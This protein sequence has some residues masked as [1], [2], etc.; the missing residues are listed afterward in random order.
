[1]VTPNATPDS[2]DSTEPFDFNSATYF[3]P[4]CTLIS[5]AI[6]SLFVGQISDKVGRKSVL[7][8]MG[9]LS[10]IGSIVKYF[11]RNTF[12]SFCISN[13][14]FGLFLGNLP[15]AMAYIGEMFHSKKE[16]ED[17][18]GVI[19]G[20]FVM[21]NSGGGI[22]AILMAESG[23]FAPLW[24]GA[25]LMA[26]SC[27]G[28]SRYMI[29]P[30]KE[31]L[32]RGDGE[33]EDENTIKRPDAIDKCGVGN[34]IIGA[35]LDNIGSTG[36]FPLCLSPLAIEQYYADLVDQGLDPIMSINGYMWLSVM[37]ALMVIPSTYMTP[38]V[39][40]KIGV[41]GACVLGNILTGFVTMGL[42]FIGNGV[43]N[44][45]HF[46]GFVVVMYGG[47]PFTV[48]SQL[49]TG[50]MLDVLAPQD[51]IGYVQGLN[52]AAMNFGMALA[53]WLLGLLAD[54]AGTN[55]AIWTGIGFSFAAAL[56]NY[57]LTWRPEMGRS[58]PPLPIQRKVLKG[59]EEEWVRKALRG[60]YIPPDVYYQLNI[61]RALKKQP[62]LIPLVKLYEEDKAELKALA[63]HSRE[64]MEFKIQL[65]DHLLG[66]IHSKVIGMNAAEMTEVL[67]VAL[68]GGSKEQSEEAE[69]R[70]GKWV[71]DYMKDNGYNPHTSSL[72]IKQMV[73]NAFPPLYQGDLTPDSLEEA[74]L[75]TRKI[76][77]MH[78][79]A[80][81][82]RKKYS[83]SK[84][85]ST[86]GH[87]N[88]YS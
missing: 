58:I 70:L 60:E 42:L 86:S 80:V 43:A 44:E 30:T 40:S 55:A 88:F 33:E 29:E 57:P 25:G 81:R 19:V 13:L 20:C 37:V 46:I 77:L 75:N 45:A 22:I 2:W 28:M 73:L 85:L 3:L 35:L 47:F 31:K 9:I 66:E 52:N 10:T 78:L 50:P 7:M 82:R 4:L 15:V 18:L 71:V 32:V 38:Y 36:L 41:A 11:T 65:I 24:V 5:V 14:I 48:F 6:A 79:H 62:F 68:A 84:T 74:L 49:T 27:L 54:Y 8:K 26:L 64:T 17:Q 61:H 21:G 53:P 51:K 34:I 16:K 1:M 83:V 23:L 63:D 67:N 59:E 69:R 39:F 87:Q 72:Q 56:A 76:T 12:W